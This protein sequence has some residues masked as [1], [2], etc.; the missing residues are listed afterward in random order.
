MIWW[1][2]MILVTHAKSYIETM[3]RRDLGGKPSKWRW[4]LVL[5]WKIPEFC[6]VGTAR[7]KISIFRVFREPF[8]PAHSLQEGNSFTPNQW[9]RWKA[10]TLKVCLLLAWRV[11][12]QAFGRY[13][14]WRVPK[15]SHMTV[16]KIENL[17]IEICTCRKIYWFQKC[18][19]LRPMTQNNEVIAEKPF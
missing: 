14:P 10:E 1:Y 6:S 9:H 11:C 16:S 2:D 8:D 13:R 3:G 17:H 15:S 19:S 7:S 5:Q 4:G 18:Y 12:D